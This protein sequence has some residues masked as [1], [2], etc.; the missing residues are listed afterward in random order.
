MNWSPL[1]GGK[2]KAD[3]RVQEALRDQAV[4]TY[5]QTVLDALKEAEDAI[6]AIAREDERQSLLKS[7]LAANREAAD[8]A[9]RLYTQGQVDFL[10]V[11]QT[12]RAVFQSE[13]QL[14]T[15]ARNAAANRIALCKA[16]GG[17]W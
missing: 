13:E 10:N 3:I 6:T 5:R 11:L 14:A 2:I 4:L 1:Q 12:Q 17:G 8:L 16:I 7:A 15:S 9:M